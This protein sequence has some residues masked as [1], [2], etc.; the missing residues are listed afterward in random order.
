MLSTMCFEHSGDSNEFYT[1]IFE[2]H[3]GDNREIIPNFRAQNALYKRFA[4]LWTS[5][6]RSLFLKQLM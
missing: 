3:C 6:L 2:P 5:E 4:P 1:Q